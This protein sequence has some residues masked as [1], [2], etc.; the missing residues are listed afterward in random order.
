MLPVENLMGVS[1]NEGTLF[2]GPYNKDPSIWGTRLGS[3]VFG[4]SLMWKSRKS[5]DVAHSW[6]GLNSDLWVLD[7]RTA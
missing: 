6:G 4:N 3:P 1:E 7:F 5:V 2:W